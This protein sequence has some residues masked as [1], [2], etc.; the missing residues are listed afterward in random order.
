MRIKVVSDSIALYYAFRYFS[1]N[2]LLFN[3]D[4][5]SVVMCKIGEY[6]GKISNYYSMCILTL[7]G[8]DR[9]VSIAYPNRFLYIK[10]NHFK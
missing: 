7:N 8:L 9:F 3:I 6:S 1:A 2:I 5:S 10:K 4:A